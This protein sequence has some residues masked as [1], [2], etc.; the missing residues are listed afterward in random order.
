[1]NN[2]SILIR[3]KIISTSPQT[4]SNMERNLSPSKNPI[5]FFN[6]TVQSPSK[7]FFK[8]NISSNNIRNLTVK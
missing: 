2:S 6:K 4:E 1:M 7:S 3:N 5:K 8:E